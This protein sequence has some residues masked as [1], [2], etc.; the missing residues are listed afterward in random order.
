MRPN[1]ARPLRSYRFAVLWALATSVGTFLGGWLGLYAGFSAGSQVEQWRGQTHSSQLGLLVV[2]LIGFAVAAAVT[3]TIQQ[4]LLK[5]KLIETSGW[6]LYSVAA[7]ALSAVTMN[8]CAQFTAVP[9]NPGG[10][11]GG[12]GMGVAV[13]VAQGWVLRTLSYRALVWMPVNALAGG[14]GFGLLHGFAPLATLPYGLLTAAA[15]SWLL[16]HGAKSS[17]KTKAPVV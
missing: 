2:V 1:Q 15:L 6:V 16:Q 17:L 7:A 14:L 8:L 5:R 12:V 10:I 4:Q 3:A 9:I 11:S 13:G